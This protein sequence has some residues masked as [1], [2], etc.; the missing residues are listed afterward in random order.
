[1]TRILHSDSAWSSWNFDPM[2]R[3][4]KTLWRDGTTADLA[5][6][7]AGMTEKARNAQTSVTFGRDAAGRVVREH[8]GE[9]WVATTYDDENRVIAIETS[10]GF[11]QR[12]ERD[13]RGRAVAIRVSHQGELRWSVDNFYGADGVVT[14][15]F[16]GGLRTEWQYDAFSRPLRHRLSVRD[17]HQTRE[18]VW[19]AE[20]RLRELRDSQRGTWVFEYDEF[21]RLSG[22]RMADGTFYPHRMDAVGNLILS[23]FEGPR[24]YGAAGEILA[25]DRAAYQYDGRGRRIRKE[26]AAGSWNYRW[27][28]SGMLSR[29]E[30]PDRSF[31]EFTYDA[32]GRRVA[33]HSNGD[34]WRWVWNQNV[35][36]HE[37][38]ARAGS[39]DAS[40]DLESLITWVFD[41][42]GL[43]PIAKLE[44]TTAYTIVSDH[45][46]TPL[47][48][49]DGGGNRQWFAEL[50]LR[51][52]CINGS[53]ERT[54]CPLR[55]PGQYEDIETGLYYNRFRYYD[56]DAGSYMS[57][58]PLRLEGGGVF[59]GYVFNPMVAS[60]PLGLH[61]VTA[62][63]QEKG[64]S[65]VEDVTGPRGGSKFKS[66]PG[67]KSI[68]G[69]TGDSEQ[70]VLSRLEET[71][72]PGELK[73]STVKITSEG[74]FIRLPDGRVVRASPIK[75]CDDCQGAMKDFTRR[76]KSTIEYKAG[77]ATYSFKNGKMT[78]CG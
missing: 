36:I 41:P 74:D 55:H 38:R 14:S 70:K 64:S 24:T 1:V 26:S 23:G 77:D 46:G 13:D 19:G 35:P 20:L 73:G 30:R 67:A 78:K 28:D 60:D 68:P 52:E 43:I 25:S 65:A 32:L 34:V 56:P 76:H 40:P 54:R 12:I 22:F 39:N 7:P 44:G 33:K 66:D 57:Q 6:D 3:I 53:D 48:L 62:T 49:W 8:E 58:D 69:R 16:P 61:V 11:E 59:Y 75:P 29:V 10:L 2:G 4:T 15:Q 51:A 17:F 71:K 47:S 72:T 31:V 27:L 21:D 18:Y 63:F 9:I 50:G 45:L 42:D 37:W 5:Y